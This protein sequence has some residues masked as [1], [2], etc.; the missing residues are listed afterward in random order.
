ME[1]PESGIKDLPQY[2]T[3]IDAVEAC[4]I[5]ESCKHILKEK[6]SSEREVS[7]YRTCSEDAKTSPEEITNPCIYTKESGK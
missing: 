6:C 1:D 3:F 5:E 2:D 4:N 7:I